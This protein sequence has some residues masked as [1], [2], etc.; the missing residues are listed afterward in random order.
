MNAR[1][2][3]Q[4]ALAL[5]VVTAF[6]V[7][8]IAQAPV[9]PQ[10]LIIDPPTTTELEVSIWTDQ[11]EY[12]VG[13]LV[14]ISYEVNKA[15]YIYIWDIT[16]EGDVQVVFPNAAYPGG[17]NNYVQA[18][19]HQLPQSF[20]VAPPLGTE[21]L[22][23]LATTQPVDIST[24]PMSNPALFQ[25]QVEVQILGLLLENER[26]WNF[27]H[28]EIVDE[29]PP[30]YG[31]VLITSNPTGA[32]INLDGTN[33]GYTPRTHYISQGLHRITISKPGYSSYNVVLIIFG[34]GTRTVHADLVALFPTNIGPTAAFSYTPTSPAI[35]GWV[36]FDASASIDPD[37]AIVSY[38]WS[39]GDGST[40]SGSAVWHRF[41][42]A[43]TY[44]VTLTVIDN[45]GASD[46]ATQS[47]QVGPSN[48]S[49]VA[50]FTFSP[51]NPTPSSWVQ[52]DAGSSFDPDG[53]IVSYSW[54]FGDGTPAQA[55]QIVY[56]PFSAGGTYTVTL[57]VTDNDGASAS[58]TLPVVVASTA[59]QPPAAAF[60]FSPTNPSPSTWVRFDAG[61]SSDG[62]GTL[63]SY[64]WNFGDGSAAQTGQ[65][66]YHPFSSAGTYTVSL[67]VTDNGGASDTESQSITVGQVGQAPVASFTYSPL[68]P[69][70]GQQM[71]FDASSSFDPDG[72]IVQ[73][74]W[75]LDGD[76]STDTS[77]SSGTVTYVSAGVVNVTLQ[78][79]DNDGLTATATQSILIS[80]VSGPSGAPMM[81][82]PG[83]YI[84][85]TDSWHVTVS[86]GSGWASAHSY[87][88]EL[89]TDGAF[90][91][92]ND[93]FDGGVIPLG[94]VIEP[95]EGEKT[96][97]FEGS[98]ASG[99][100]DH[101]FRVP[102][103]NSIWMDLKLDMDGD[104]TLDQSTSFIYLRHALV[105]PPDAPMVV[106]LPSGSS[107]ELLPTIDFRIGSAVTYTE[108]ARWVIWRTTISALEA[109]I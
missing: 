96:V 89:R 95:Q 69:A 4:G 41:T 68:A 98:L 35:G 16:P 97:V 99:S 80:P 64:Q 94:L 45:D 48:Q 49:P 58:S 34:T 82:L 53:S 25:Q 21:F 32:S 2:W 30:N 92:V 61:A 36:Q 87:R 86:A 59:N 60:S 79:V 50:A 73:Y 31:T 8:G 62:D 77:G 104:G 1:T 76:G 54:N 108:T 6:A 13:E 3:K 39:F 88:I 44:A 38:N 46:T 75:D 100:V 52:F 40:E 72:T 70:V 93:E 11:A 63:V 14:T 22:Q 55:G 74:L 10:G 51:S 84:W 106:G 78:V 5:L 19:V 26:T 56:H 29:P 101:T 109:A 83:F 15:A 91:D 90:V 47:I 43:G 37:G 27:T 24:F 57:T 103:S 102:D 9:Y 23:I 20:P 7:V 12:Q 28:F 42:S 85:G 18:G 67:T 66:V 17:L 65:I 107:A 33:I 105:N 71:T 81:S